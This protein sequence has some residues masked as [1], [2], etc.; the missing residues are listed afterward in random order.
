MDVTFLNC[1]T[2]RQRMQGPRE[3]NPAVRLAGYRIPCPVRIAPACNNHSSLPFR[4]APRQGT[5]AVVAA[6]RLTAKGLL[7]GVEGAG[8]R[9]A[10]PGAGGGGG[11]GADGGRPGQAKAALEQQEGPLPAGAV[12]VPG[13]ELRLAL[14]QP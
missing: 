4:A 12:L 9:L 3:L 10:L 14:P 6:Q 5:A 13:L 1:L 11:E 7:L 8:L 2:L